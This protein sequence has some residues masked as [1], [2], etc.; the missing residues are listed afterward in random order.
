M[1]VFPVEDGVIIKS[2]CESPEEGALEQAR[3]L[4]RLPFA[5]RQVCLMPDVHQGYGMPI[6]GVLAAGGAVI[7]DA[8]GVDIA[9]G[10]AAMKLPISEI[11]T[12]K[13]KKL[14]G[15]IRERIPLGFNRH[16]E[17]QDSAYMPVR[18]CDF[19]MGS[20]GVIED[21]WDQALCQLGTLGGGNHFIEIQKGSDGYIWIML[22]SG[23]RN[24]G[25]QVAD[26]WNKEAVE[27]NER[28]HSAVPREW[29]LAFLPLDSL[30][31]EQYLDEMRFC[32]KFAEGNRRLMMDRIMDGVAEL[33]I[34]AKSLLRI[35]V[36]HN[37]ARMENHFGKNVMV[38]RKGA[39]SAKM[40]EVGIIP[41]SQGTASY[42]VEGKG[43]LESFQSCS[44]GAGRRM[45]RKAAIRTLDLETEKARLDNQ[46]ILHSIRG[47]QDLDEAAGA[48][49]DISVVMAEQSDLVDILVEL[50]PLAVIKG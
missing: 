24:L 18:T 46:G 21:Q 17:P 25:K 45:G 19:T 6:G 31:G 40:G 11:P 2:W 16:K 14:M 38:H 37:Y 22:H 49:K 4:A 12:D 30:E 42:I 28:W 41:G 1:K 23:S 33:G 26:Y 39:T 20:S 3:N 44:H 5:F 7:P 9:C 48:Y 10:V 29:Q 50:H 8:V 47:N 13:L 35:D 43:N 36:A 34:A 32:V 15:Y 27:L